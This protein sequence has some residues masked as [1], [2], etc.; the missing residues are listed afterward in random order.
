MKKIFLTIILSLTIIIY[1]TII[2][3][4]VAQA[5][6][7]LEN[8]V[9]E[10]YNEIYVVASALAVVM[11]IIGGYRYVTSQGNP[12][13]LGEAKAIIYGALAGLAVLILGKL[14]L[15]TIGIM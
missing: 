15:K 7:S 4:Q 10:R 8:W 6:S 1:P 3:T 2:L 5:Q 11:V 9:W 14:I 12:E 13:A